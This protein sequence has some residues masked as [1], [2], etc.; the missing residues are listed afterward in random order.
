[1]GLLLHN[2]SGPGPGGGVWK[3]GELDPTTR[4]PGPHEPGSYPGLALTQQR[5]LRRFDDVKGVHS[6]TCTY[7]VLHAN[8][9][10]AASRAP[11]RTSKNTRYRA[12]LRVIHAE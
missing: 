12:L 2:G 5:Y 9:S 11:A 3:G 8:A 4:P 10:F 1:M 7:F 6:A